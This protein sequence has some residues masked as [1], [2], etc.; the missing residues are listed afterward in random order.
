M[1]SLNFVLSTGD[2]IKV[3]CSLE[4]TLDE[5]CE[6]IS[7]RALPN[8]ELLIFHNG[9]LMNPFMT[10]KGLGLGHRATLVAINKR[11]KDGSRKANFLQNMANRTLPYDDISQ[12][13]QIKQAQIEE[14]QRIKDMY[15][16]LLQYNPDYIKIFDQMVQSI[17]RQKD[18]LASKGPTFQTVIPTEHILQEEPLPS[19]F[20]VSLHRDNN[21]HTGKIGENSLLPEK[22]IPSTKM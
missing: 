9:K 8:H 13:K 7:L 17:E 5:V 12:K 22:F 10:I 3:F 20:D 18:T 6:R 1:S 21:I 16:N 11:R 14:F 15:L 4:Q 2:H 19:L